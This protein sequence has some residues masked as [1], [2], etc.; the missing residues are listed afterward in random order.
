VFLRSSGS[1]TQK[2]KTHESPRASDFR[3]RIIFIASDCIKLGVNLRFNLTG[4]NNEVTNYVQTLDMVTDNIGM[5]RTL[6][7]PIVISS[8]IDDDIQDELR[9]TLDIQARLL[10]GLI[11]ARW[12]VIARGL[13]K[14]VTP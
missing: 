12:I 4:V 14:M 5:S 7:L 11:H 10:Y 3:G 9:A 2:A 8:P 1:A 6:L 13:Q